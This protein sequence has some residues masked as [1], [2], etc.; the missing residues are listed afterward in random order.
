MKNKALPILLL[1]SC[2]VADLT[3]A[4]REVDCRP[5]DIEFVIEKFNASVAQYPK[6][7][8]IRHIE[9]DE[10]YE[11]LQFII[12]LTSGLSSTKS[13][14]ERCQKVSQFL[15]RLFQAIQY[16]ATSSSMNTAYYI[17]E[18]SETRIKLPFPDEE[19][20]LIAL[21]LRQ[22]KHTADDFGVEPIRKC[23]DTDQINTFLQDHLRPQDYLY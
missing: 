4:G 7:P 19:K 21:G 20:H 14:E 10:L 6:H 15:E 18:F 16:T 2:A 1:A 12:C 11:D 9:Y 5:D 3:H 13:V 8:L 17:S 22:I 23:L